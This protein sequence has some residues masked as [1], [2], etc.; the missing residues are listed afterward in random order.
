MG[1]DAMMGAGGSIASPILVVVGLLVLG[2]VRIRL[3]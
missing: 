1:I 3:L 2:G